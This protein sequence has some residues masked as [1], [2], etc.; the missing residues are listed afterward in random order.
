MGLTFSRW[1]LILLPMVLLLAVA[2]IVVAVRMW[3]AR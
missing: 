1:I 2:A 3:R